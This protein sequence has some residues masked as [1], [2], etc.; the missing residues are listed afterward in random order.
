MGDY[1]RELRKISTWLVGG[2]PLVHEILSE[3]DRISSKMPTF[4]QCSLEKKVQLSP[5]E[6][7][8]CSFQ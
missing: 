7:P 6:S 3:T 8:L 4:N 2:P 1:V 5:G